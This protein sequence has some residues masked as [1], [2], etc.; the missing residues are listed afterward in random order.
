MRAVE[1]GAASGIGRA[2]ALRLAR[3]ARGAGKTAKIA[4]VDVAAAKTKLDA[5]AEEVRKLDAEALA[6]HADMATADAPG[7]AVGDAVTRLGGLDALVSR[8]EEARVG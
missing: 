7:R 8:S 1:T 2:T 3:D 6:I 5:G 4:I